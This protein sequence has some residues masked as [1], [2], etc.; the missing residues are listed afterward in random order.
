MRDAGCRTQGTGT[1]QSRE[2]NFCLC[3]INIEARFGAGFLV[4]GAGL[5]VL[6]PLLLRRLLQGGPVRI[7]PLRFPQL[8]LKQKHR[9]VLFLLQMLHIVAIAP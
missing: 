3:L 6:G 1:A 4:L 9:N 7:F 2:I 8:K 5:L